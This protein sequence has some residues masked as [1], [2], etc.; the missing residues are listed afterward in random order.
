MSDILVVFGEGGHS[1]QMHR[2]VSHLTFNNFKVISLVDKIGISKSFAN[3]ENVTRPLR[4]KHGSNIF[5][6]LINFCVN[7]YIVVKI[8]FKNNISCLIST[9][10]GICIIPSVFCRILGKNVIFIETWS[11]FKTKSFTGRFMY[12][13]ATHFYVQNKELL[14]LYPNAIYCGRL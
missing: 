3:H 9:G 2:L 12:L 11:R 1:S 14:V 5:S 6:M 7:F 8:L 10:P 4:G 13:I